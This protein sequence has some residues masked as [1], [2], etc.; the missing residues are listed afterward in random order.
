LDGFNGG[1][2][3]IPADLDADWH[4]RAAAIIEDLSVGAASNVVS[5]AP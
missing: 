3:K 2:T 4:L 1:G 5:A